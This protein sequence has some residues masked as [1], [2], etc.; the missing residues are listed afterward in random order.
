MALLACDRTVM[1]LR[2]LSNSARGTTVIGK[3]V[4][5]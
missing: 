2:L 3:E 5:V 4:A 1:E